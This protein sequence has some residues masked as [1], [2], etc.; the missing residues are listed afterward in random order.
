MQKSGVKAIRYNETGW[1][2][3]VLVGIGGVFR[4][5]ITLCFPLLASVNTLYLLQLP[6]LDLW[7]VY[8]RRLVVYLSSCHADPGGFCMSY[9]SFHRL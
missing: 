3:P 5:S 8:K 9:R 6:L 4:N 7:L 2:S 1:N